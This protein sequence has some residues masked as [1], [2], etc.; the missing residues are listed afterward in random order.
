AWN[1]A[2]T[3]SIYNIV[4]G[5]DLTYYYSLKNSNF[6]NDPTN[7]LQTQWDGQIIRNG[8]RLPY[9]FWKP[10]YASAISKQPKVT[11]VQFGNGYQQR[12]SDSLNFNLAKF[13]LSFDNRNEEEA[14]SILHFLEQRG[15]KEAFIYNMPTIFSKSNFTT[16]F[17]CSDWSAAYNSYRLYSI[18]ATFEE[19]PA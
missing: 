6:N 12:I 9:F 18:K 5:S 14:V 10:S 1:S 16:E 15:G 2:T 7:T 17:V 3:Y 13:D 8:A 4:S 11:K 19:V